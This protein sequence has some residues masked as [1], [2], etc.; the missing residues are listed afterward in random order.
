VEVDHKIV[1][2]DFHHIAAALE[3]LELDTPVRD[4]KEA[5]H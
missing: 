2:Q 1:Q 4:P 3:E 5:T